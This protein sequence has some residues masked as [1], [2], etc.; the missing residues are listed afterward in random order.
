M[1]TFYFGIFYSVSNFHIVQIDFFQS[2]IVIS[3]LFNTFFY[4]GV[5]FAF[6][7]T[8][9][10]RQPAFYDFRGANLYQKSGKFRKRFLKCTF[11]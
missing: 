7:G 2:W 6:C 4:I 10:R 11:T 5:V 3:Q 1:L 8:L 9:M